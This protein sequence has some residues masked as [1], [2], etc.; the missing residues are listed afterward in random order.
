[1]VTATTLAMAPVARP[2]VA[3]KVT[4]A[5]PAEKDVDAVTSRVEPSPYNAS[6]VYCRVPV[7]GIEAVAGVILMETKLPGSPPL[8]AHPDTKA[9]SSNARNHIF[10]NILYLFILCPLLGDY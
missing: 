2:L 8:L 6:A 5:V 3:P 10:D 7:T 4:P 9:T 1:M